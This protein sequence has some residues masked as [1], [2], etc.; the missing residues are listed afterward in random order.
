MLSRIGYLFFIGLLLT[1]CSQPEQGPEPQ[2]AA[3]LLEE[4]DAVLD[5]DSIRL[6]EMLLRKAIRLSEETED[7]HTHYIAYQR[8]AEALSQGNPE[9]ALRLMKK[10]LAIY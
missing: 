8:L 9:E 6:G 7:W 5:N 3:R 10:S 2:M 4:A 1:A